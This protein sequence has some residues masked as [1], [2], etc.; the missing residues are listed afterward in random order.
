MAKYKPNGPF[1]NCVMLRGGL[2]DELRDLVKIALKS[3]TTERCQ[4]RYVIVERP[5]NTSRQTIVSNMMQL[6]YFTWK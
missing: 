1:T 6:R 5:T 2:S 4:N 3:V